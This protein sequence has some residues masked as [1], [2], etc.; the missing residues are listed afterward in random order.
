M[1]DYK[2]YAFFTYNSLGATGL[3]V[4]CTI[5]DSTGSLLSGLSATEVGGGFYYLLYT[6]ILDADYLFLFSTTSSMVDVPQVGSLYSSRYDTPSDVWNFNTRTVTAF[7]SLVSDIWN[8]GTREL[9][10]FGTL[11]SDIWSNATRTLTSMSIFAGEIWSYA[12]RT[13]TQAVV[14]VQAPSNLNVNSVVFYTN[15][16]NTA[17]AYNVSETEEMWFTL[18]SSAGLLDSQSTIQIS[19]TGGLI[20]A[21]GQTPSSVGLTS[22]DGSISVSGSTTSVYISSNAAPVLFGVS[23][24][25][26]TGEIK[27]KTSASIVTVVSQFPVEVR[28]SLTRAV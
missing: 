10:S 26:L 8:F 11:V 15:A 5:Y 24:N 12:S 21:N 6:P 16:T 20:Y 14:R 25:N 4:T 27:T 9:T 28:H 22:S 23:P 13:L 18:K 3:P 2:A 19:K 17:V 7:G 1:P